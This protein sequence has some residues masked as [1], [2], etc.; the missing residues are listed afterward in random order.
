M[1]LV[2]DLSLETQKILKRIYQDSQHHLV[3]Q[4]A[5]CILLSFQGWSLSQLRQLYGISRKT[6]YT[7]LTRWEDERLVGLYDRAGRGR[8]AKLNDA[9]KQQV[10]AWVQA[11]PKNL[12]KVLS[13]VEAAWGIRISKD[14]LKRV[15]KQFEMRWLRMKR[16]LAG[17]PDS[18]ELEVKLE[19]L[20]QLKEQEK[21]GEISLRY[22]DEAG[23]SLVPSVPYGWQDKGSRITLK[24]QSS[25]RLNVLG[26]LNTQN[27]L[28]AEVYLG[29]T[30]S[31]RVIR[32]L[33]QFSQT[34]EQTTVVVLNQASI[35]TSE[36]MIEKLEEW[37][38]NKLELF[39]LPTYSPQ[40][41]LIETLWRFMKY[42][43]IEVAAYQDWK[44]LIAY[45]KKVLG[46]VGTEYVINFA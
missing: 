43:W 45:V 26:L 35:H 20:K 4:R 3:R 12:K 11:E 9:Q 6:L 33:D 5:Q 44:S 39:W 16:G 19:R 14:T 23:F 15:L 28:V 37:R 8:K 1:R 22:L 31:E 40:F 10:R 7:W 27:E 25:Q 38:K 2:R 46:K 21:Q 17:K 36:A 32:F 18:W 34:L 41:N 42:E 13:Q 29:T 24:S 30:R